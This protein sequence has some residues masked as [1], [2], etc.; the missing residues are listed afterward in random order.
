MDQSSRERPR[1]RQLRRSAR[2]RSALFS[3]PACGELP[4]RADDSTP[5]GS[6]PARAAGALR[7]RA[8]ARPGL[9]PKMD[10]LCQ[11]GR[12]MS[13]SDSIPPAEPVT[14]AQALDDAGADARL[15]A[16]FAHHQA[17]RLAEAEAIYR[18][19]LAALP[20][21]PVA[22]HLLGLLLDQRGQG[23][24]ALELIRKAVQHDP[25]YAPAYYD[26]GN[27]ERTRGRTDEAEQAFRRAVELWP[28]WPEAQYNYG[29]LLDARGDLAAAAGAYRAAVAAKPDYLKALLA[30]SSV[31][32][33][34]GDLDAAID[35]CRKALALDPADADAH[36]GLGTMLQKQGRLDDAAAEYRRALDL[37]PDFAEAHGYLASVY[38]A[39]R[40]LDAAAASYR[41]AIVFKPDF[42][43]AHG[44]LG[45]VLQ[46]Q[47]RYDEAAASYRSALALKP[48]L[49]EVHRSLGAVLS[50]LEDSGAA[51]A[52]FRRAL[53]LKPDY[54]EV[55][56]SLASALMAQGRLEQAAAAY[57]K[58]LEL[59]PGLAD[60]HGSLLLLYGYHTV[61]DPAEY[62]ALARAWER[63]CVPE[64]ERRAA[65]ARALT[66]APLAARRLR[67]GYVSGDYCRHAVSYFIEQVFAR[68]DRTRVEVFAYS[69]NDYRDAIT[70]RIQREADHWVPIAGMP[71]DAV[72][73]RIEADR[74]DVLIDLSGHT[75]HNRLGVFARR[76]A[77]VQAHYL[78][79]FA[80]TGLT[81][82]DYWLG[83]EILIPPAMDEQFAERVWRLPRTWVA[84]APLTAA[85]QPAWRPAPDAAV[86]IG[87]F[88]NLGKLTPA[89]IALWARVLHA[90]P[91]GAP[92]AEG[93]GARQREPAQAHAGRVRGARHRGRAHRAAARRQLDRLHGRVQP[94]RRRARSDR[95]TR[96]RCDD[97]RYALDGRAGDPHAGRPPGIA[98]HRVASHRD[99]P[100]GVDCR[101]RGR[102]RGEGGR[103]GAQRRAAR[104]GAPHPARAHGAQSVVRL[105]RPGGEPGGRVLR[106]VPA[107]ERRPRD[108][109]T[110]AG[111]AG[112]RIVALPW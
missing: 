12:T 76:A 50:E 98:V 80:T 5:H 88:N 36:A 110:R 62:L 66:R 40:D 81:E 108:A 71:D 73:N 49:I 51:A 111:D 17:G 59:Q 91:G 38:H 10:F 4:L 65:A 84:Y 77:P 54:A 19:V 90:L 37:R 96:R 101:V 46:Q 44:N 22:L 33:R 27:I 94:P 92:A 7:D 39:K 9:L 57:R 60:A 75:A 11:Q 15:E 86:R 100:P 21:H 34:L 61:A 8:N 64:S 29:L 52:S 23:D 69:S 43:E 58:A 104:G 13:A 67:V 102:V 70:D 112:S 41:D 63:G 18:S 87:S 78:G 95:R 105:T 31:L 48:D 3:T 1:N 109:L 103:A 93:Q 97:L 82:M 53:E 28:E 83:D 79:F 106:N 14:A 74:I 107:L 56:A 42:A 20:E 45:S 24:A 47:R 26:L 6:R 35:S 32:R 68:H 2:T 89:T 16:G 25:E 99:R 72:L 85:P 55:H 30:L